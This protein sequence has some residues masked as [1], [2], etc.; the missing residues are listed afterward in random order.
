MI[1][2]AVRRTGESTVH[3]GQAAE[4]I[5]VEV[6]V[7]FAERVAAGPRPDSAPLMTTAKGLTLQEAVQWCGGQL[8]VRETPRLRPA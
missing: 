7:A 5:A 1:D 6:L 4:W 8:T 2:A 3:G